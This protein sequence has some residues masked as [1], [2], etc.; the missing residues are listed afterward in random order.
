MSIVVRMAASLSAF[1][2][3]ANSD[4]TMCLMRLHQH[5]NKSNA[6][7]KIPKTRAPLEIIAALGATG[8][9]VTSYPSWRSC[10]AGRCRRRLSGAG[11][12]RFRQTLPSSKSP[13]PSSLPGHT[14]CQRGAT[15][16]DQSGGVLQ[17]AVEFVEYS[18]WGGH[19]R[20][21]S[22]VT[23]P[24]PRRV[25]PVCATKR[26]QCGNW[27][28]GTGGG[29]PSAARSWVQELAPSASWRAAASAM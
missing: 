19:G 15:E 6:V 8:M 17:V 16:Q 3:K 23:R 12:V 25:T 2:L 11:C 13:Q 9:S 21:R 14:Q 20:T 4:H 10:P 24:G 26:V 1:V 27:P 7:R 22:Q 28:A 29:A 18:F 5:H